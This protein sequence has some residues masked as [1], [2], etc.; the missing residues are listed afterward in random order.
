MNWFKDADHARWLDQ[1]GDR[2]LAFGRASAVD[3]G[4]GWLDERGAV[5]PHPGVPL[6]VTCRMTHVYALAQMRGLDGAA[7]LVDH[8]V[9]ALLGPLRDA[10]YGGWFQASGGS[11]PEDA[12]KLHYAHAF[13]VLAGAS[14]TLAGHADGPGLL[15]HALAV[16][17]ERFWDEDAQL[18]R[19]NF[20]RDW[21][22]SEAYRGANSNMHCVEAY[23]AAADVTGRKD[24]LLR[25][26]AITARMID[27]FARDNDWLLPEHFSA[28]WEPRLDYNAT[29]PAHPFRPFGVTIGHLLE[30]A[31]LVLDVEAA[32]AA[33]GFEPPAWALDAARALY[34]TAVEAG[35]AVDGADGFVY[36]IDFRRVPVVKERMHWVAAEAIGAAAALATRTGEARYADDYR[37]WWGYV[38]DHHLDADGG[39]WWHELGTDN[40]PSRTV[41]NGKPDL[42][43][44]YQATL[45]PRMPLTPALAPALSQGIEPAG[46]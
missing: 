33:A 45:F 13:V 41:W 25:A 31:R 1:E 35:W 4:F 12:A 11:T 23:L 38:R 36:T 37:R 8:G 21:S 22:H 9:A 5:D 39:S 26:L 17:D 2:L 34:D 29:D 10:E 28:A 14:A 32:V 30:W 46:E 18:G 20:A 42:Y 19:E 24:L 44:A 27:G 40:L 16:H 43:H 7:P 15:D 6:W 3:G